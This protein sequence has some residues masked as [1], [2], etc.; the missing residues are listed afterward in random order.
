MLTILKH[1]FGLLDITIL[2]RLRKPLLIR[3]NDLMSV[4]EFHPEL[5]HCLYGD[6]ATINIV[7]LSC[8]QF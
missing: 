6:L 4:V 3:I 7:L 8:E 2:N 5:N 1:K